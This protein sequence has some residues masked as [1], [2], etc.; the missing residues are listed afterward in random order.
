M[1][2]YI[3]QFGKAKENITMN[4]TTFDGKNKVCVV[5]PKHPT[6]KTK[7]KTLSFLL[8]ELD[9]HTAYTKYKEIKIRG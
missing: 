9:D 2:K 8:D 6:K 7:E 4:A 5:A 3:K 1:K